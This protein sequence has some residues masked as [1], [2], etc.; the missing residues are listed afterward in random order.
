MLC[1]Q[2]NIES[3]VKSNC[4]LLRCPIRQEKTAGTGFASIMVHILNVHYIH[5]LIMCPSHDF[6]LFFSSYLFRPIRLKRGNL[7]LQNRNTACIKHHITFSVNYMYSGTA[8]PCIDCAFYIIEGYFHLVCNLT[9]SYIF[10][11]SVYTRTITLQYRNVKWF[12]ENPIKKTDLLV[13]SLLSP[14]SQ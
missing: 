2:C 11:W 13:S 10:V 12:K 6:F 8:E 5:A 14:C 1:C 7:H 3:S 4:V 9:L